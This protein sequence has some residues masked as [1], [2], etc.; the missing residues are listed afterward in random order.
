MHSDAYIVVKVKKGRLRRRVPLPVFIG[1]SGACDVVVNSEALAPIS[2]VIRHHDRMLRCTNIKTGVEATISSLEQFGL[3][4]SGP[5][6]WPHFSPK[7]FWRKI[8]M[9]PWRRYVMECAA[10]AEAFYPLLLSAALLLFCGLV[11]SGAYCYYHTKDHSEDIRHLGWDVMSGDLIGAS[12]RRFGYEK[13]ATFMFELPKGG[14]KDHVLLSFVTTGIN[15]PQELRMTLNEHQ[16]FVSDVES[17]CVAAECEK[18]VHIPMN[19]LRGG[20]NV[21]KIIHRPIESGYMVRGIHVRKVP[22]LTEME[23]EHVRVWLILAQRLYDERGVVPENLV[24]AK[25]HVAKALHLLGNRIGD[26]ALLNKGRV[27]AQEIDQEFKDQARQLWSS[28]QVQIRLQ[29]FDSAAKPLQIL[30]KMYPDPTT[31][32]HQEVKERLQQLRDLNI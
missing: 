19:L 18:Q 14:I 22:P 25:H 27:L 23:R 21:L 12:P 2:Y 15:Y 31:K 20:A 11:G 30:L 24:N 29:R 9:E 4:I 26:S 28:A 8:G 1:N 7:N 13:G 32:E 10:S 5:F 17:G 3:K 16:I 6:P